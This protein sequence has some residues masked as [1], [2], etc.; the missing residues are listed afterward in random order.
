[1]DIAAARDGLRMTIDIENGEKQSVSF[2]AG[3]TKTIELNRY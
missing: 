2:N 3:E 1:M